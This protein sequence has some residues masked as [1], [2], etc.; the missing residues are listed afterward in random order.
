MSNPEYPDQER[1]NIPPD[2]Q[3]FGSNYPYPGFPPPAPG[4]NFPPA[5]Y[6]PPGNYQ[7]NYPPPGYQPYGYG[8]GS[9]GYPFPGGGIAGMGKAGFWIRLVAYFID[10]IILSIGGFIA[11]FI[12]GIIVALAAS[13]T[14]SYQTVTNVASLIGGLLGLLVYLGYIFIVANYPKGN[15][16]GKMALGLRVVDASGN[17]PPVGSLILRY[18]VGYIVSGILCYIGFLMVGFDENKQGLHDKIAKTYVVVREQP[19][20][21]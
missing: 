6:P 20:Y 9:Y 14:T 3:S 2:S 15:T 18:T 4:N 7:G 16:L 13:R 21:Y 10:T 11:G 5:N 8:Y 1:P 17:V 19:R 12:A